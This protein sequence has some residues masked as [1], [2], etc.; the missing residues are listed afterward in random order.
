MHKSRAKSKVLMVHRR[1]GKGWFG[2]HEGLAAYM[3]RLK[4]PP[5]KMKVP[6]FHAWTV[7]PNFP[8]SRQAEGELA[9]FIPQWARPEVTWNDASRGHNKADHTFN[10]VFPE[11]NG[12]WEIKSAHDPE[13][14]QTV[15]LDY[16]HVQ[17]C[18]D[19]LE[20]A[21]NKLLPTLRDPDRLGL[22]VWEGIPPDDP[23][24]WFAR[25]F[26]WA[27]EQSPDVALAFQLGYD[28]NEELP[29]EVRENIE[30]DLEFMQEREWR[31]MY[32]AELSEGTGAFLGSVDGCV[33]GE[34]I[35][36]P[37]EGRRYVMGVD[38]AK[39]VDFTVLIVMDA[40]RR[41]VVHVERFGGMDW[42][43]QEEAI[44][45]ATQ[46]FRCRRVVM[47]STGVGD[48]LHDR[49]LYRGLPVEAFLFTN[50]SKYR[51]MTELAVAVEKRTVQFPNIPAMLREMKALRAERLPSGRSRVEAPAGQHDDYPCAL[52]LALSACD[53][54][55]EFRIEGAL[56]SSS[57][58]VGE[59]NEPRVGSGAYL[60]RQRRM[61]KLEQRA[62]AS[63]VT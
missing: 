38:V 19:I 41:A 24:H 16:L 7:V 47:D 15:G 44:I 26:A 11:G 61:A 60:M 36:G 17:E 9:L 55:P 31:R 1:G 32:L 59:G 63:G 13:S 46:D 14:L 49:L 25:L 4:A 39:K 2:H 3:G 23:G 5:G 53:P 30:R 45:R 18:Q 37:E 12:F 29:A 8:Q 48:P 10:L 52:A 58:I 27:A 22:S 51:V 50:E 33:G 6:K 57:Y 34:Q 35:S 43:V 21:F 20:A 40:E 62:E 28:K 56:G 54:P 42:V